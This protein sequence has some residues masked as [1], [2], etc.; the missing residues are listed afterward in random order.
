MIGP[1]SKF[2]I[3]LLLFS[4]T[5]SFSAGS[6]TWRLIIPAYNTT[7]SIVAGFSVADYGATGDGI[8]D[9]TSIFQARLN[10]LGTLGGGVLFV[11]KGKYVIR[12]NLTIPRGVILQGELK[13]PVKGEAVEGTI[14]MGYAG[15][16]NKKATPLITL[17]TQ[18]G[19]MDLAIWYPEQNPDAIVEYPPS[20]LIGRTGVRGNSFGNI[21]NVMFVNSYIAMLY[22]VLNGGAGPVINGVYGSPLSVGIELDQI[23]DV[24]RLE[25]L[26]FSP[27]YWSGSGLPNSPAPN[28]A[29]TTW[30]YEN[31][32]GIVMRRNDWSYTC[33][34]NI[35]GYNIGFHAAPSL[36][37][38]G[39]APNG[40]HYQMTFTNCKTGLFFDEIAPSGMLL[41]RINT[42]DCDT[43]IAVGP[44]CSQVVELHTCKF[45]GSKTAISTQKSTLVKM[46][47][48]QSVINDGNINTQ[49]GILSAMDCD[50]DNPS[51]QLNISSNG[52]ALLTGN[53][54][55]ETAKINNSSFFLG[56][57]ID[58]A[59]VNVEK[60][61]ELPVFVSETPQ[62]TRKVLYVANNAPFGAKADGTT[63]N[64]NAIQSALN[65]ASVDGGGIVF[66]APGKYKVLG[67]LDIPS[68]VEL[69]GATDIGSLPMGPGSV[70]EV[71]A[72]RNSPTDRPF[73]RL[74]PNSGIR[75]FTINYPEQVSSQLPNIAKYPYTIQ[76]MGSN[77]YII[78]VGFRASTY[79]IDLFTNKCDN[80]Y[81]DWVSGHFFDI[82]IQVGG[83]SQN[84]KVYNT[85][86][87]L[88]GYSSGHESKWGSW[89]N[90]IVGTADAIYDYGAKNLDVLV[91]GNCQNQLLYNN[92]EYGAY[93]GIFFTN[94]DGAGPT[95][96]CVGLGLD[97][98]TIPI[99]V[100]GMGA[101]GFDLINTQVVS[102]GKTNSSFIETTAGYNSRISFFNADFWNTPTNCI[103]MKGG[104]INL[105]QAFFRDQATNAFANLTDG[106]LVVNN[107]VIAQSTKTVNVGDE[108]KLSIQSTIVDPIAIDTTKCDL[109]LNN[110]SFRK[111]P[112]NPLG[113]VSRLGWIATASEKSSSAKNAIDN[114]PDT[115]WTLVGQVAEQWIAVNMNA[116]NTFN[117]IIIEAIKSPKDYPVGYKIYISNDGINWGEAIAS[118]KGVSGMTI[119]NINTV[120]VRHFKIEQTGSATN[121]WSI[122]EIYLFNGDNLLSL[123]KD[124]R[125]NNISKS[126]YRI[127]PNPV[128]SQNSV[129]ISCKNAILLNIKLY[130]VNGDLLSEKRVMH[131]T[132]NEVYTFSTENLLPGVYFM[133][134][135]TEKSIETR[136]LIVNQK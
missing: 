134:L 69:K 51:P 98:T 119:I 130:T 29:Y 46:L 67:N 105:H 82:G 31:G 87:K 2:I 11:P 117:Q 33:Y 75:G 89:P 122:H 121:N 132:E 50:F 37:S 62:P 88:N 86:G 112:F 55:K 54:F 94:S 126:E 35:E 120:T 72:G 40:H 73:L 109:W 93:R 44:H 103:N 52:R 71:Y 124:L 26:D 24:G 100:D 115:R 25:W 47:L 90:S 58:H 34:V 1:K 23:S 45:S 68:N 42:I 77:V 76:G 127:F 129:S 128:N 96:K 27:A 14:L 60:M 15:K 65:Q 4:F 64:T 113:V 19:I 53:R 56:S 20:I 9:V 21:K 63:D 114:N 97:G 79:G 3:S 22:N 131:T 107:S 110:M 74:A 118:G 7:E 8:T 13:K 108:P 80:H 116:L 59:A 28:S 85:M 95:G 104:I 30:I 38:A 78:N 49:G 12:G 91:L 101:T 10:S 84:G 48:M 81:V 106:K 41:A 102:H 18:S 57:I 83:G 125:M 136:K 17:D 36:S 111:I 66:L 43:A 70:L 5:I 16:G 39:S 61:P 133:Q 32:T 99:Y 123:G 6:Q 92:F 135:E